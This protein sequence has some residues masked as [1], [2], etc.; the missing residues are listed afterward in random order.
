[1]DWHKLNY[2]R[3]QTHMPLSFCLFHLGCHFP[4]FPWQA[5]WLE[6]FQQSPWVL[7]NL[8]IPGTEFL[9]G[10]KTPNPKLMPAACTRESSTQTKAGRGCR[11]GGV[12]PWRAARDGAQSCWGRTRRGNNSS[13]VPVSQLAW[14]CSPQRP[15]AKNNPAP[16]VASLEGWPCGCRTNAGTAIKIMCI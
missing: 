16:A 8:R 1:M 13:E 4:S 2:L 10:E 7:A 11:A 5:Y 15:A 3:K 6:T 12:F 14:G 9:Q